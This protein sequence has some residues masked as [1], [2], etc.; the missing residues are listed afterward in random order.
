M[1]DY[2]GAPGGES[3]ERDTIRDNIEQYYTSSRNSTFGAY[4]GG[5]KKESEGKLEYELDFD[6]IKQLA[7]RMSTN[8][9]KYPPFN[10]KKPM[11]VESLKQTAL[12]H[13][14]EIIEGRYEDDGRVYGH[15]ES[16]VLNMMFINY[17]LKNKV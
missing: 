17:Q 2:I 10:W 16:V 14:L 8:K 3:F 5:D 15:L 4:L 12:R 7:E 13:M 1:K 9:C 6:F 11:D